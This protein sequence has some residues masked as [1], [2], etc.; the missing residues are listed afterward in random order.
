M[1]TTPIMQIVQLAPEEVM[2]NIET[3]RELLDKIF[4]KGYTYKGYTPERF[5]IFL[6][7]A[8]LILTNLIN[9]FGKKGKVELCEADQNLIH[10]TFQEASALLV[11]STLSTLNAIG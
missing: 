2:S 9:D 8:I 11:S 6:Q 1:N 10:L 3:F 7:G 5:N 4:N